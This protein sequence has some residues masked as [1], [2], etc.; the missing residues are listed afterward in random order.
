[1]ALPTSA[2]DADREGVPPT[3]R[4]LVQAHRDATGDSLH[5]LEARSANGETR[6]HFSYWHKILKGKVRNFP[7]S[8]ETFTGIARALGTSE[9]AI[10]L[11]YARE[12]GIPV[13]MP[14]F[15]S[16]V[17][18]SADSIPPAEQRLLLQYIR[19][20]S[21]GEQTMPRRP[22]DDDGSDVSAEEIERRGLIPG[23]RVAAA[24]EPRKLADGC[25]QN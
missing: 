18:S 20:R 23:R 15:A 9:L 22:L 17:P 25:S 3:I 11:G 7:T 16:Q 14:A 8:P 10:V 19:V 12:F 6:V 24:Q 13:R 4:E 1:M 21:T 5:A 2:G